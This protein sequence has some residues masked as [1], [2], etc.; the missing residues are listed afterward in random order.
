MDVYEEEAAYFFEDRSNSII[1]DDVLA[2]LATF[3]NVMITSH[4]GSFTDVAQTKIVE[5]T[6]ENIREFELGKRGGE[7]TNAVVMPK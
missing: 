7:L 1:T 4:Q 2:R 6:L 3:N 5:C